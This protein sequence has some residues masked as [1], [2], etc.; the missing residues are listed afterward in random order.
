MHNNS[1]WLKQIGIGC[2]SAALLCCAMLVG[3]PSA[4]AGDPINGGKL[5]NQHCKKCHGADGKSSFPG[6]ADFS[7][8]EGLLKADGELQQKINNGKGMMPAFRSMLTEEEIFDVI[9]YL[10]KLRR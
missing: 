5:Y 9:T 1:H 8:G 6:V 3:V 4:M 10:R 7:R 2:R